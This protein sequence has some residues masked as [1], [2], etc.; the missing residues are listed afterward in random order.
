MIAAKWDVTTKCNFRCSHCSV[1]GIYFSG[2]PYHELTLAER[3]LV[4]DN[5]AKGGVTDISL[6]GGEP[7]TLGRQLLTLVAHAKK[8][9]MSVGI[10]TNGSLLSEETCRGLI[11][12]GADRIA[13]SLEST[14]AA[15]HEQMRGPGTFDKLLTNLHRFVA[16]RGGGKYPRLLINSVLTRVNRDG[17]VDIARLSHSLGADEWNALT[18]NYVGNAEKNLPELVIDS[19]EHTAV[20]LE[21]ARQLPSLTRESREFTINVQLL[22]PLAWEYLIKKYG[23][24]SPWPQIC[25]SAARSLVYIA[26]N[27]DMHVCDR[28][29]GGIYANAQIKGED[30]L[31]VNLVA[32]S[33]ADTWIA[34]QYATMF[35]FARDPETYKDYH[36]CRCCKYLAAGLCEPCPLYSLE[37]SSLTFSQ[38]LEAKEFLGDIS[39]PVEWDMIPANEQRGRYEEAW[40]LTDQE[41]VEESFDILSRPAHLAG[42]RH[43][44]YANG[45]AILFHADTMQTLKLNPMANAI[46]ESLDGRRTAEEIIAHASELYTAASESLAHK[47]PEA[48]EL[49]QLTAR[50]KG[51]LTLMQEQGF[52]VPGQ[53]A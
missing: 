10:A 37:G 32:N 36:P 31:P 15:K 51:L 29:H 2:Q 53:V 47:S 38:C 30:I 4:L 26:P 35:Q 23:V 8:L 19:K 6:L 42:T 28:V 40:G 7:L 39:G 41:R 48:N 21:L 5:L 22:F 44:R 18:L 3:M 25:C 45:D 49:V 9:G 43:F 24:T 33:F 12:L 1:A 14:Q 27:G 17:F 20:A 13:V 52:V 16:V 11:D 34:N 50:T 46:W